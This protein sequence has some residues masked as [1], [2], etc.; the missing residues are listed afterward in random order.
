MKG[1]DIIAVKQGMRLN[2]SNNYDNGKLSID[3]ISSIGINQ[4]RSRESPDT[5]MSYPGTDAAY[6]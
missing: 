1:S 6:Y 3:L 4:S 5:L 2:G